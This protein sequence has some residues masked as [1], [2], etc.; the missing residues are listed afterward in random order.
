[1]LHAVYTDAPVS[2]EQTQRVDTLR[3]AVAKAERTQARCL[4]NMADPEMP[5]LEMKAA[6]VDAQKQLR[7]L[8]FEL[9]EA[10]NT[11]ARAA[12]P[13]DATIEALAKDLASH[14][15]QSWDDKH[16]FMRS[17]V[18]EIRTDGKAI[19]IEVSI[20]AQLL[21]QSEQ[22]GGH[23]PFPYNE[24]GSDNLAFAAAQ[25]SDR[26]IDSHQKPVPSALQRPISFVI[27]TLMQ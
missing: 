5:R 24:D 14:E 18:S 8:Q 26:H 2:E 20:P 22:R 3:A 7:A 10:E 1:M 12:R 25:V 21:A 4:E 15:P 9:A 13:D 16:A 17:V 6:Y 27:N 19:T 23:Y 11:N